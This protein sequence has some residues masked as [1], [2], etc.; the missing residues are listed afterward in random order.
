[1][2]KHLQKLLLI[3]A[4]LFVPWG[5]GAQML[6]E[7]TFS[8]GV[9][10][11][12]WINM[13]TATQILTPAGNTSLAS[14]LQNIGFSFPFG[15]DYYT[16]YSVNTDGNLR[17]G[18]TVTGTSYSSLPFSSSDA[19]TDSPKINAFGCDGYGASGLHYVKAMNTVDADNDSLLVVEFCLGS[20]PLL[21]YYKL[22]KWQIHLYPN[23]NVE[24]VFPRASDIPDTVPYV[25]HQ[26]GMCVNSADGW[27][28]SLATNTA[29][30]FTAGSTTTNARGTWY[31]AGRYYRFERPTCPKP[32]A[33]AVHNLVANSFNISWT[34]TSDA[35]AWIVRLL[36]DSTTVY[37]NVENA[38]PV[39][40]TGL[41]PT[42]DYTVQVAG[43]CQN[44]DTSLF[45]TKVVHT[46]CV[47][48]DTLPY[49]MNFDSVAGEA[50]TSAPT[51]NLPACWSYHNT[52]TANSYRGYPM[53]YN[54]SSKAHSGTNSVYFYS[55]HGDA[56]S[57]QI[58][59][60]PPTDSA[61]L[62]LSAMQLSFWMRAAGADF[63]SDSA[64]VII[65]VM[66][67]PTD[68]GTFVPIETV[69]S[70]GS[71]TY[72]QHSVILA[73]YNG[74]HGRV[75]IKTPRP[76]AGSNG[77]Y[78]DDIALEEA[79]SCLPVH[80]L[81]V[82]HVTPDTIGLTWSPLGNETAWIINIG[83]DEFM[84][85]D[86]VYDVGD[87]TANTDYTVS[88]RAYCSVTD[89]SDAVTVSVRTPCQ[90]ITTLPF[91]ENFEASGIMSTTTSVN[92][93]PTCWMNHNTGTNTSYSGYP[94]VHSYPIY[95]HNG[96]NAMR[97]HT[98]YPEGTF[99]DQIAIMP[100]IDSTLLPLSGLQ[101]TFWMRAVNA[102][103][104]S[105][106]VVGVMTNPE[107]AGTFVPIETIYTHGSTTYA[108]HT[109]LFGCYHGR[110]GRI[111]FKVPQPNTGYN[112]LYIDDVTIDYM[113]PCPHVGNL[114]VINTTPDSICIS[115]SP[116]GTET[117]WVVGD[118]TNEYIANDT[119][120][121]F[122]GLEP[123]TQ[124]TLTVRALCGGGSDT[125]TAVSITAS[126]PCSSLSLLPYREDFDSHVGYTSN[127]ASVNNLPPCWNYINHGTRNNYMGYPII[128]NNYAYSGGNCMRY[129]MFHTAADS[130]QYAILPPTDS[131]PYPINTLKLSFYMR[132]GNANS[133]TYKAEAIVGVITNPVD[134]RTFVPIDT[135][136]AIGVTT[137]SR[138]EIDFS[139]YNGPHGCI[140]FMF[141]QPVGSGYNYNSG[142]IDD[143]VLDQIP[144]CPPVVNLTASNITGN[145][146]DLSWV[147]TN[148]YS[149]WNVE[150]GISG[151]TIGTGT[152]ISAIDTT[153]MTLTGLLTNTAYDVYV[154]PNCSG[155]IVGLALVTFRT[156]CGTIDSLPFFEDF[157]GYPVGS[158]SYT[159]PDCGIPCW[160]RI[161]NATQYHYGIIGNPSSWPVGGH[162][163]TGFLYY[164]FPPT[165][166]N[167]ADWLITVLPP[168]NT[169]LHPMNSLQFSFWVKM[170]NPTAYGEIVVGVMTDPTQDST[171]FS[172]DTILVYGNVYDKKEVMLSSYTDSGNYIALRFTRNPA[173]LSYFFVDDITV[174]P[175][176]VCLPVEYITHTGNDSTSLTL[177]WVNVGTATSWSVEYGTSGF[178]PGTGTIVTASS[179]PFTILGLTPTTEYDIYIT[180]ICSGGSTL[181]RMATFRTANRHLS[182]PFDCNFE[183]TIQNACWA[184]ENGTNY[185]RWVIGNATNHGGTHSLYISADNGVNNDYLISSSNSVNYAYADLVVP[186]PG[187]YVYSFDW[188]CNGESYNDFLRV[189]LIPAS[190]TPTAS[191]FLPPGLTSYSLPTSWIPLD[192]GCK[193]NLQ[194]SWQNR[195]EAVT[196]P[197]AGVYHLAFI[198]RCNGSDGSMPPPAID[199]ISLY[200]SPCIRPDS[201]I[202]N[203]LTTT[204]ANFS[205]S[206][207]GTATEWQYQLGDDSIYTV[208][209]TNATFAG[210]TTNTAY[211]FKV[212]SVC[213]SGDT[214]YWR[215]YNFRT[216]CTYISLPYTQNFETETQGSYTSNSFANCWFRLNNGIYYFGYPYISNYSDYN[217][218]PGGRQ[219]LYW[220]NSVTMGTYGDYQCVVL[221]GFDT[222]V[223]TNELQLSFWVRANHTTYTLSFQ[224]G[225]M[226]DPGNIATFEGVDTISITGTNWTEVTIPLSA[227]T[228]NGH[229]VA[230]K[231]DRP[232]DFWHASLDDFTLD[233]ITTCH[234]PD[235]VYASDSSAS[236]ITLNWIDIDPAIQ[237]QVEYGPHGYS[238]GSS[239]GTL[240]TTYTHPVVINGLTPLTQYDFYVRPVCNEDDT[241]RWAH[242]TTLATAMCDN[243]LIASTGNSASPGTTSQYPVNNFYNYTLTETIIDSAELGGVMDIEYI[244]YYYDTTVAMT[245][246]NNCTIYFQPTTLS[247]FSSTSAVVALDTTT[248]VKVYTGSLN[249]SQ[250]WNYFMLDTIYH[251]DGNGNL[252]V[253]V[254]DNSGS[255]NSNSYKFKANPCIG[256]K[257]LHYYSDT[258][259]P[260]VM[261]P[262]SFN[263]S[264]Y[265]DSS[266]V[267]MQLISCSAP[268]CHK[269]VITSLTHTYESATVT[270]T[271]DSTFY[272][273]NIKEDSD[274]DYFNPD[275][276]VTGNSFTFNRLNPATDYTIRIRQDCTADSLGY[277]DWV[278]IRF[279]TDSLPCF[280]PD[281]LTASNITN[282]TASF[283]WVPVGLETMWEL[284]VW[285]SGGLDSVYSATS[286]PVTV[287]GFTS[288]VPYQAA[289]RPL[290]GSFHNIVGEWGDTISF[291][292]TVCPDVTGLNPTDVTSYSVTLAWDTNPSA[293]GWTIEY[294]YSGFDQGT[295]NT[296]N[297]S[298]NSYTVSGLTDNMQYD[299]HVRAICGTDWY[300]EN[301]ASATATTMPQDPQDCDPVTDLT[302]SNITE[303]SAL[304][305]WTPGNTGNEWEVVLTDNAGA[306]IS[307]A[308]TT[309]HQYHLNGLNPSTTYITKVRTICGDGQYSSYLNLSFTTTTIG[310]DD[311]AGASCTI[312]PN[313]TSF[314]TTISVAGVSGMIRIAIYDMSGREVASEILEC[315]TDCTKSMNVEKLTQGAYFVR[316]TGDSVSMVKKL[317]VR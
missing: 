237:W 165:T 39:Y 34:D 37:S 179:V 256:N 32:I 299:F 284:H 245:H 316:I 3:V 99:S 118:G 225:V 172:L 213:G 129:Y 143:I 91:V 282:S 116:M 134:A 138:Y 9:D 212:R 61:A 304:I 182:L 180:P 49:V 194:S 206:E 240:L 296:I 261:N 56:Y 54:N 4:I 82:T 67:D 63:L 137:Y 189:A 107:D 78:I 302:A 246:K 230:V 252:L 255:Y 58:A 201:I 1:M 40:F 139:S 119:L 290:C 317:I 24:M 300:S 94:I 221:P 272:E 89:T 268:F 144:D 291:T 262:S 241:A 13:D 70:Y 85:F 285:Y 97:F 222:S 15:E 192:G 104:N 158:A 25:F 19:N 226:T 231:A 269:P 109:V 101:V 294:G 234:V 156:A 265:I 62:P 306:T 120:F 100:P 112:N 315:S 17:L 31:E 105:Y 166:A 266:R 18:P 69:S 125:S 162:S 314:T 243:S 45:F 12:K 183:D 23:G 103:Y 174:E 276:P 202:L 50:S 247:T 307:E 124:Y 27:V 161:D 57:D 64:Y 53:V 280:A 30:A 154:S 293:L 136:N 218:T 264:K 232:T 79:P 110:H 159:P 123:N 41:T 48:L 164:Y 88:V 87:L 148:G 146:A 83:T 275:Y 22:Y 185:N 297:T 228:G 215:T 135:V 178:T 96:N 170:D 279:T 113:P 196:I 81:A 142:Y 127:T 51:N 288:G 36:A 287:G 73:A 260:D 209:S 6:G 43:L 298:T 229:F 106:V 254:D 205:W 236:S 26:C 274:S 131:L 160:Q 66:T 250:G 93:L 74:P 235:F 244:S 186:T 283:D 130:N 198:F 281:S 278:T 211:S 177:S 35:T 157:E 2:Q 122:G 150:Y 270:W 187:E 176:P 203:N 303:N 75:A 295:G 217:H 102:T 7:Y 20:Y 238:R 181:T 199:N 68:A 289:A 151:F 153:S 263:G 267:V 59:I 311:A 223:N 207:M 147:D 72:E 133:S 258:Y 111:A 38:Y 47:G 11:T 286:H 214:S 163:G 77:V 184:L 171:F 305:T 308:S 140:A 193:L 188:K 46:P 114:T 309:E 8:T 141:P 233:Y 312:Y 76:T 60:M 200:Y 145:S 33:I 16:Q 216:P 10:T 208:Y 273:I 28:I 257:T 310:I 152:I 173:T 126:T 92:N 259:N 313:P 44:G 90:N 95:A 224:I 210:L 168:I 249:C 204:S 197:T 175:I 80:N 239:A 253:I 149:S 167:Y 14:S 29:T 242:P 5:A 251:Y 115:W 190:E 191:P 195:T 292:T 98:Y 169:T 42:S 271:G 220:H 219:G 52:S 301:W 121:T 117:E 277:S 21:Y 227:Y 155:N 132:A 55:F 86:T 128:I 248:A 84:V 65:G 108:E 71:T